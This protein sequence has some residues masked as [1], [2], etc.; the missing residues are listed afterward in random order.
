MVEGPSHA[1]NF[2]SSRL[3]SIASST[4]RLAEAGS[5]G[6]D[7]AA[8]RSNKADG[9]ATSVSASLCTVKGGSVSAFVL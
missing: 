7:P 3:V 6:G 2:A 9:S 8:L 5:S 1:G 4:A